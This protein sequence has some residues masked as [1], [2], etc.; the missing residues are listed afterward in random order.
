M[1]RPRDS[2]RSRLYA[3]EWEVF[4][5]PKMEFKSIGELEDYFWTVLENR[6]VQARYPVAKDI[7]AGSI[8]LKVANGFGL[9]NAMT[10][11]DGQRVWISFPRKVRTKW[12]VVHEIA[13]VV[14]PQEAALHGREFARVYLHLMK[15]IFGHDI[16]NN[17]KSAMK[18]H[19]CKYSRH[20]T[21][22]TNPITQEEK[23]VMLDRL[24]IG[25]KK[26]L[27]TNG[28]SSPHSPSITA[29]ENSST[30]PPT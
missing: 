5:W 28:T 26:W 12:T 22:W 25:R 9:R 29:S 3:A 11:W 1:K 16:E 24:L 8:E 6:H 21:R 7:V 19:K 15:L 13:H 20:H 18:K 4:G 17:L 30:H 23:D 27:I 10:I 2:Q 14:A